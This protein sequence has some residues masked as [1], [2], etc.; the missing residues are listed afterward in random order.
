MRYSNTKN[1]SRT[2]KIHNP[3]SQKEVIK[4]INRLTRLSNKK[5]ELLLYHGLPI[6]I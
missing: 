5:V 1:N 2:G 6:R 3:Y 4:E